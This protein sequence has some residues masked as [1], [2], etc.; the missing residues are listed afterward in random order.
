MLKLFKGSF[1][2]FRRR[3]NIP[4]RYRHAAM[5]CDS[6]DTEHVGT[7]KGIGFCLSLPLYLA[8]RRSRLDGWGVRVVLPVCPRETLHITEDERVQLMIAKLQTN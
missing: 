7:E 8:H 5:P 4:L 3:V 2:T 6:H 1:E